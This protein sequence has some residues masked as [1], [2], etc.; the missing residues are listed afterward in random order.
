MRRTILAIA[1]ALLL[2]AAPAA[3]D[4]H[5][6]PDK[7]KTPG[8]PLLTVPDQRAAICLTQLM[9]DTVA[10][11]D[12]ISLT[13]ICKPDYSKCIR[14][15]SAEEKKAVYAEYGVPGDHRGFCDVTQGCEVDH[16]ISIEIGGSN[17]QKN[18]WPEPY[19]GQPWNAHVKDR[20][21]NFY[22]DQICTGKMLLTTAQ[23]EIANDWVAAFKKRIGPQPE[24]E[25]R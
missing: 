20:L 23:Q 13:M 17:E 18:L 22:H 9:G 19:S 6:L 2:T 5:L 10:V 4:D 24:S 15:V 11:G 14:N 7:A 16:L 21:E 25:Q 1:S 8:E 3:A 12:A